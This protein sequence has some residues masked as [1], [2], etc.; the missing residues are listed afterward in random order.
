MLRQGDLGEGFA[1]AWALTRGWTV[2][3]PIGNCAD[4]DLLA[5]TGDSVRRIQVKTCR[6]RVVGGRFSVTLCTRGGNRS[7]DGIVK[8]FSP[9]R[10]DDL[11]IHTADGRRWFIPAAAVAGSTGITVGGPKYAEFEVE[12]GP[13]LTLSSPPRRDTEAVKRGGL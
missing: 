4:Y 1:V 9:K 13:P 5:D 3:V 12:P 7:W 11:Y 8:R 10:C 2:A 6:R